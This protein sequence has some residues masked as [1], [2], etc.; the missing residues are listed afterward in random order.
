[1]KIKKTATMVLAAVLMA[2]APLAVTVNNAVSVKASA[3]ET[4]G[5]NDTNEDG[6]AEERLFLVS[7]ASIG[8]RLT[9]SPTRAAAGTIVTMTVEPDENHVIRKIGVANMD[10]SV[11]Y[12]VTKQPDGTYTF[13]MPACNV[14]VLAQFATA[15]DV[16]LSTAGFGTAVV[17]ENP[18][19]VGEE[20]T[21]TAT[22]DEEY[23]VDKVTVKKADGSEVSVT[24]KH[25][26]RYSFTMPNEAVDASVSFKI[27]EY[28]LHF[29]V[30][31]E[32]GEMTVNRIDAPKGDTPTIT[33]VLDD[34][35]EFSDF[36]VKDTDGNEIELTDKKDG[37]YT[38]VM[39]GSDVII[40]G[41]FK[42]IETSE[43]AASEPAS[44]EPATSEPAASEPTASD[45]VPG[46]SD[47]SDSG[48]GL[49]TG[50]D[51]QPTGISLAIAPAVLAASAAGILLK[52]TK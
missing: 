38:F 35:G 21:V 19:K 29:N 22:P 5:G 3:V 48:D 50:D 30:K 16:N 10:A 18:A 40:S 11:Y 17:S 7:A 46:G 51:Q 27:K 9:V 42:K 28:D 20:V 2:F 45:V 14:S 34:G 8:G 15:Y 4:D 24:N 32:G 13:I 12:D 6:E 1:M 49:N 52:K 26:G 25:D 33:V 41:T 31:G 47:E 37:T 44:S 36:T 39:P 23:V 43:P